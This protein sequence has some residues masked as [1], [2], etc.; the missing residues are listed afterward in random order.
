MA[1][2]SICHRCALRIQ[3]TADRTLSQRAF[4]TTPSIG[5][6]IPSFAESSNPDLNIALNTIREKH[7]IPSYLRRRERNLIFGD[8]NRQNLIDNPQSVAIADEEI[9]LHWLDRKREIPNRN[10]V[11]TEAINLIINGESK[12]WQ[13]LPALMQGLKEGTKKPLSDALMEKIIRRAV[14]KGRLG[15]ALLCLQQAA[16][17]GMTLK[18]EVVL[19]LV[20][21]GLRAVP[22]EQG[23]EKDLLEKAVKNA[24][25]VAA[26]LESE[27]H[28][29]GT[30]L[31]ENDPRTRVEV[32]G[33]FLELVAVYAFKFQGKKDSKE[34][35]VKSYAE[36]L[37]SRLDKTGAK[38]S[39]IPTVEKGMQWPLLQAI[40]IWHGLHVAKQVLGDSMPNPELVD[41]ILAKYEQNIEKAVAKLESRD[42][43]EGSYEDQAIM[44]WTSCI[45]D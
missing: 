42:P 38:V 40:P 24:S 9:P 45:R 1:S 11:V 22:Q 13:N 10:K 41:D 17:T 44:A 12:D 29:G 21:H 3:R 43:Q 6:G 4:S 19:R 14:L 34:G 31:V 36:R 39:R 8:K 28:G 18:N 26:L 27:E 35:L 2:P 20:V 7:F 5:R 23:W 37:V 32:L 25:A 33:T 15:H 16:R 30:V